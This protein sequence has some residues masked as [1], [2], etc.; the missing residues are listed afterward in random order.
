MRA[1]RAQRYLNARWIAR[2]VELGLV[3]ERRPQFLRIT[4]RQGHGFRV[5]LVVV[6]GQSNVV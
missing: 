2:D 5:R 4:V 3:E 1:N 6:K